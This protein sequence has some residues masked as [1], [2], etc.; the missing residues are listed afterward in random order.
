[1]NRDGNRPA[2][3]TRLYAVALIGVAA[4]AGCGNAVTST[5]PTRVSTIPTGAPLV[6]LGASGQSFAVSP[7]ASGQSFA[8]SSSVGC[9][10]A[11]EGTTI[12]D[13]TSG[14]T[15]VMPS[16]WR[17][18]L[19]DAESWLVVE[20]TH[21]SQAETWLKDGT[22]KDFAAPLVP[23]DDDK[24]VNLSL[25][26][27]ADDPGKTLAT[28]A[29]EYGKTIAGARSGR[30][31]RT[32]SLQVPAGPAIRV[33]ATYP[34]P[35]GSFD[36]NDRLVAYILRQ[37]SRIYYLVFVSR[38]ST[39]DQYADRFLCMARSFRQVTGPGTSP[40]SK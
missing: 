1:M 38:D 24:M 27:E 20:G 29:S 6:S 8:A 35:G 13:A 9:P 39:G 37:D 2:F 36:F 23:Q 10:S 3:V 17:Q 32:D 21:G 40:S 33:T 26:V 25:F 30:V 5:L 12:T 11:G 28:L 7:S 19:P 34:H 14:F 22:M 16:N 4:A 31:T 18:L 15:M